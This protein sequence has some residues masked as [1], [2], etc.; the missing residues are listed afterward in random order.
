LER[1]FDTTRVHDM[2]DEA[3]EEIFKEDEAIRNRRAQLLAERS[4]MEAGLKSAR[5]LAAKKNLKVVSILSSSFAEFTAKVVLTF[6]LQYDTTA[7]ESEILE[8]SDIS[9]PAAVVNPP[10]PQ[11]QRRPETPE[12]SRL[13][14]VRSSNTFYSGAPPTQVPS[15]PYIDNTSPSR[16]SAPAAVPPPV[17]PYVPQSGDGIRVRGDNDVSRDDRSGRRVGGSTGMPGG[18][19]EDDARRYAAGRR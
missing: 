7:I 5:R 1:I 6:D 2:P 18:Y 9:F 12:P 17:P 4:S 11:R 19:T 8:N 16:P 14:S 3:I 15:S 13:S 10:L